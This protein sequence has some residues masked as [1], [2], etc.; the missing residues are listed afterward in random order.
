MI[1]VSDIQPKARKGYTGAKGVD[2]HTCYSAE[3]EHGKSIRL[4]GYHQHK[5]FNITFNIGD[6]AEYDSYNLKYM[7]KIVKITANTVTIDGKNTGVGNKRLSLYEFA[8]RNYDF[9][10]EKISAQNHETS[11]HI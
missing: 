11:L 3:I 6:I 4:Y 8:W 1:T 2:N 9:D 7:G 5:E 10:L